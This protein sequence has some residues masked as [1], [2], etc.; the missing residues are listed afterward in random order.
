MRSA[1]LGFAKWIID[2]LE[3]PNYLS[4]R[5]RS[6]LQGEKIYGSEE[7]FWSDVL[8]PS[9]YKSKAKNPVTREGDVVI[10]KNFQLS[11]WCPRLP[12]LYWTRMGK[13]T[14]Y[15]TSKRLKDSPALGMH[16]EP[17][18]K[19]QLMSRGGLGT[20]R[21]SKHD[22]LH[23]YGA[24]T[25]GILDAAVP[26]LVSSNV[27]SNI[28]RFSKRNPLMEVDLKGVVRII[29]QTYHQGY[30]GPHI[31][32]LCLYVDS[33]LNAKKYTSDFSLSANAWTIYHDPR[34]R[35]KVNRFGY[36]YC[37][38]N[39]VDESSIINATNWVNNYIDDYTKGR[40]YPIT[41][42]DEQVCRF[43]SAVLPLKNI[44]DGNI[45]YDALGSL[46]GGVDFRQQNPFI[47]SQYY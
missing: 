26:V 14:R 13:L 44:I 27:A 31:P 18:D 30:W 40:G 10:L 2:Y 21:L 20:I 22:R 32:K 24:T 16:F 39:P 7:E 45:D 46:F 34:A 17:Y 9:F 15:K 11:P 43:D 37:S 6:V 29:P 8:G 36:T 1:F 47:E 12:G 4:I 25:S 35:Y 41:D 28:L 23:F 19:M 3:I 38:F 42:F 5:T 33:I